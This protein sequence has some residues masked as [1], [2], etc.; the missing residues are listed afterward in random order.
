M[1]SWNLLAPISLLLLPPL[2]LALPLGAQ[3]GDYTV[4]ND[5]AF[6]PQKREQYFQAWNINFRSE[7]MRIFLTFAIGNFGPG[8]LNNG[9][10]LVISGRDANFRATGEYDDNSLKANPG[11]NVFIIN[12][13]SKLSL[14]EQG[15]TARAELN[16][17][18]I[19]IRIP[20]PGKGIRLSPGKIPL[21]KG[22]FVKADLPVT[23]A[24]AEA[25]LEF[26]GKK[27]TYSGFAGIDHVLT[28]VSPHY[29]SRRFILIRSNSPA[30]GVYAGGY[31]ASPDNKGG[32]YVRLFIMNGERIRTSGVL[33]KAVESESKLNPLPGAFVSDRTN[34]QFKTDTG[35]CTLEATA[36]HFL[37]GIDLLWDVTP[38]LRWV[39]HFFFAKPFNIHYDGVVHLKCNGFEGSVTD[40]S[41][42]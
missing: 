4:P 38:L 27:Y 8:D 21:F 14:N 42:K 31:I 1:K 17:Y 23:D 10:A 15:F 25:E 34:L 32:D 13:V 5:F 20:A 22:K 26:N 11:E 7:E 12:N 19:R 29:Y 18:R 33:L 39:L 35:E 24:R 41:Q 40:F 30:D 3:N 6:Q 37:G 16:G 28:D 36:K 2:L 9:I